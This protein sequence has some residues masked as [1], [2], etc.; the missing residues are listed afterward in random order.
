METTHLILRGHTTRMDDPMSLRAGTYGN[1]PI[2][3]L[4]TVGALPDTI[5]RWA[6][7]GRVIDQAT[8]TSDQRIAL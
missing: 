6:S 1:Q 2:K 8:P 3:K 7:L 5:V 4:V